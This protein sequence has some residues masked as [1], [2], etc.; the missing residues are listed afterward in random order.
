MTI[1]GSTK[2]DLPNFLAPGDRPQPMR[3]RVGGT[4]RALLMMFGSTS[5]YGAATPI[6]NPVDGLRVLGLLS[7][8][9]PASLALSYSGIGLVVGSW[10]LIVRRAAPARAR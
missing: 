3:R 5:S 8:I 1:G 7:R 4:P 9:G 6:P 10:F 2:A